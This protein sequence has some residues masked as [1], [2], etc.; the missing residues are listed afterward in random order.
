MSNVSKSYLRPTMSPVPENS[1]FVEEQDSW[2]SPAFGYKGDIATT[3]GPLS[4]ARL[5]PN[6][7]N[8]VKSPPLPSFTR[9]AFNGEITPP[10]SDNGSNDAENSVG[11]NRVG[12]ANGMHSHQQSLR[13]MR[14][15]QST[16]SKP[17][18][19]FTHRGRATINAHGPL[20]AQQAP[21]EKQPVKEPAPSATSK[22]EKKSMFS[23]GFGK[24][25]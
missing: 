15:M 2:R 8:G 14:S 10:D 24:K 3:E 18:T 4:N 12:I 25:K 19:Y 7:A 11:E 17:R 9:Q 23:I 5:A 21:P 6:R 20:R 13:S 16:A 22:N 1:N